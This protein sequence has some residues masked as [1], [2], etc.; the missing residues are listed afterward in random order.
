MANLSPGK[1]VLL[2]FL[3]AVIVYSNSLGGEFVYDDAYFV[4]KNINIRNLENIPSFFVNPCAVAFEALSQDVYRPVTAISYAIDY[5][6]WK[7]DTF[8][9]HLMNVLFHSFNAILLFTLLALIFQDLFVAF[10]AAIF[11]VCHPIQTEVVAWI[12]GRSSVLFLFFYLA[13]FILYALFLHNSK[14]AYLAMSLALYAISLFSKEMALSLP[15]LLVAYDAHFYKKEGLKKKL[16]RYLPYFALA[17]FFV[18]VRYLVLR[19]VGQCGWWGGGPY[20]TFV[21]MIQAVGEYIKLLFFPLKLCAF[22]VVNIYRTLA[23]TKVLMSL[24]LLA[25][26]F[27]ALPFIFRRSRK[28]S[29][30]IWWFFITLIPVSNIVPLRAIMAERFLYLPSIAFCV[31]A[32]ILIKRIDVLKP[33]RFV[34]AGKIAALAMAVIMVT[35]YSV[36]TMARNEDWKEGVTISQS[37]IKAFPLNPWGYSTLGAAYSDKELHQLAVKPL[38]KSIVLADTYFAPRNILGFC[39]VEM[40]RYEDAVRVLTG[41]LKLYPT[42]LEA[43]NSLGVAYGNL[44]KYDDAIKQFEKAMSIDR[45]FVTVYINLGATYEQMQ[46]YDKALEQYGRV[47]S[48]TRSKADVAMSYIRIGDVYLKLKEL[49]RAKEYYRKSMDLCGTEFK[50]LRKIAADRL[51]AN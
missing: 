16:F 31:L 6:F 11:F 34:K 48:V 35:A 9:Y 24:I 13:S 3:L 43:L 12:S 42:S 39:Y 4:V 50:E 27:V 33:R 45:T 20:D 10:L 40:E 36:R 30:F 38:I 46:Q 23:D 25:G 26:I 28:G 41:A 29:F 18:L 7:L 2:I 1:A 47:S 37:I 15:L 44:K 14:K 19:R 17:L 49:D 5:F 8:G 32:A 51:S 21:T 22:Y